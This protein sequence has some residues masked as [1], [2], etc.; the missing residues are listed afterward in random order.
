MKYLQHIKFTKARIVNLFILFA[1]AYNMF[2]IHY[3]TH[4]DRVIYHDVISY[5]AYL[6]ATMIYKDL[7]LDF[8]QDSAGYFSDKFWPLK[9]PDGRNVIKMSMGLSFLYAPFFV[10]GHIAAGMTGYPADGFSMP[11]KFFLTMSALFY[12][13]LGLYFLRKILE[14]YFS[15][16]VVIITLIATVLGTN[17]YFYSAIE[18]TMPHVYLF[19]LFSAF[20]YLTIR[21]YE[22]PDMESAIIIGL[23]GGLITLIRPTDIIL[24]VFFFLW[25]V[26]SLEE[27]KQR[28]LFFIKN[29]QFKIAMAL[30]FLIVWVP[31]FAYWKYATGHWLYYSYNDEGFNFLHPHI[32]DGL[33]SY[34]KG[35]LLYTPVMLLAI[36]GLALSY[37]KMKKIFFPSLIFLVLNIYIITSW[38]CW[39]YGGSFGGRPFIDSYPVLALSLAVFIKWTFTL[40]KSAKL[41]SHITIIVL[42]LLNLFQT[43]QYYGGDIHYDAMTR[44]AYWKIFLR[45][46]PDDT[47]K[48]FLDHPDYEK[49]VKK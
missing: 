37:K 10:M 24:A 21:W 25:D 23:L 12:L 19:A 34:R 31:Q 29:P 43:W 35:W 18:S 6:P 28:F 36:T 38:W 1:V 30:T 46:F 27:L 4:P 16:K 9:T 32:I 15:Q 26:K 44:K 40:K 3:W 33:F 11:Y 8:T 42:I 49:A 48:Q 45:P 41:I 22:K 20:I 13:A 7:T 17:L 47:Y 39:W 14:N 5:Y 2:N